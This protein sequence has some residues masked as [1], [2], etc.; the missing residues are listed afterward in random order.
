LGLNVN[1]I[2]KA[3]NDPNLRQKLMRDIQQGIELG[4]TGT[5]SYVIEGRVYH[6]MIPAEVFDKLLN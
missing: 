5:P 4:L 3:L 6:G 1:K 2:Q